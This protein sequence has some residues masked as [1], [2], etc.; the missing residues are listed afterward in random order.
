MLKS[1]Q[2]AW[3]EGQEKAGKRPCRPSS[4]A[5]AA[6][7]NLLGSVVGLIERSGELPG[8]NGKE[9]TLTSPKDWARGGISHRDR[10]GGH[11]LPMEYPRHQIDRVS[12]MIG[13]VHERSETLV[14]QAQAGG[15][16]ASAARL[17]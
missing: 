5:H 16:V 14:G 17:R 2:S 15:G 6:G 8:T 3:L 13:G 11:G 7:I 1:S 9:R 4:D 10:G 12:L